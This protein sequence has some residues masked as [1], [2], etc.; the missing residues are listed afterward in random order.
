MSGATVLVIKRN[1]EV[2]AN[3]D[4][5]WELHSD[6]LVLLLGMPEQLAVAAR[7]FESAE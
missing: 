6:D 7:L 4:P 1:D 3:P 5:V 2:V